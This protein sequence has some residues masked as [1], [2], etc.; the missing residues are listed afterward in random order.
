LLLPGSPSKLPR[1]RALL[2]IHIILAGQPWGHLRHGKSPRESL[3]ASEKFIGLLL[4][5]YCK[6]MCPTLRWML[7]PQRWQACL[8]PFC[9]RHPLS[10]TGASREGSSA[11]GSAIHHQVSCL[12]S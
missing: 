4:C 6:L 11:H 1:A 5:L 12:A 9:K 2:A 3:H 7:C 10:S 8:H